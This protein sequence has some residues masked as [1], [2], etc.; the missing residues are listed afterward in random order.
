MR[1]ESVIEQRANLIRSSDAKHGG[2]VVVTI[3]SEVAT[4]VGAV[5]RPEI[6]EFVGA[7]LGRVTS[8]VGKRARSRLMNRLVSLLPNSA[9]VL[10]LADPPEELKPCA[11]AIRLRALEYNSAVMLYLMRFHYSTG[12]DYMD[13][14]HLEELI[15]CGHLHAAN[16]PQ[17]WPKEARAL[18]SAFT[19]LND[20]AEELLG[21]LAKAS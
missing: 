19:A 11:D 5:N 13:P 10:I 8:D 20:A 21:R 14:D 4:E 2:A 18:L 7:I 17:E 3:N 6:A 16:I 9:I 12:L 15:G 1:I